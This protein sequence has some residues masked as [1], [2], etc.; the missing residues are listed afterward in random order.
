MINAERCA[1]SPETGGLGDPWV[2]LNV[3]GEFPRDPW[4]WIDIQ[5]ASETRKNFGVLTA[6]EKVEELSD[7]PAAPFSGLEITFEP[8]PE[9]GAWKVSVSLPESHGP[10]VIL[11]GLKNGDIVDP[12]GLIVNA[13]IYANVSELNEIKALWNGKPRGEPIFDLWT[14]A[15]SWD[16]RAF[17]VKEGDRICVGATSITGHAT[18]NI[19]E[20]AATSNGLLL[21]VTVTS[22]MRECELAP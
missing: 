21:A 14:G 7:K 12:D 5:P 17:S 8:A 22:D 19:M 1:C 6:K 9:E 15:F 4:Q 2:D 16:L 11:S 18:L 3:G 13:T 20:F 10:N